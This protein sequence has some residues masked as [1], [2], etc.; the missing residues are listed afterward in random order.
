MAMS[1]RLWI[2][3]MS[4]L[5]SLTPK[6]TPRIKQRVANCHTAEVILIQSLLVPPHT[7]RGQSISE[8]GGGPHHVW[9]G[10]AHIDTD[11]FQIS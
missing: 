10:R 4:S 6:P 1:L 2:L 8:V 9:Y 7:P 11:L 3:S 5:D